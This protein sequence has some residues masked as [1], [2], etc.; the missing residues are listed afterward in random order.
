MDDYSEFNRELLRQ[1]KQT[2]SIHNGMFDL[3]IF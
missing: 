3:D 1:L 2:I